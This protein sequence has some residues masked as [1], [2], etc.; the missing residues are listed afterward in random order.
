MLLNVLIAMAGS[1]GGSQSSGILNL[2]PLVLIF[3]VFYFLML[4]PQVKRQK[5]VARMREALKKGDRVVTTGGIIGTIAN[6]KEK[7][8]IIIVKGVIFWT[9]FALS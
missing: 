9:K 4:R 8:N 6:I 5:E 7:E 1:G 2:L 3:A